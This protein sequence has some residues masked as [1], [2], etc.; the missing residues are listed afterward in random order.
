MY[1]SVIGILA[2]LVLNIIN[3][4][5]I[6]KK[7]TAVL[8]STQKLYRRYL[9]SICFFYLT[10]IVWG[11][12]EYYNQATLLFYD[13]EL[14]FFAIALSIFLWARYVV[15]YLGEDV[16]FRSFLHYSTII[17]LIFV[18]TV[19]IINLFYP[20]VFWIDPSGVYHAAYFRYVIFASQLILLFLVAGFTIYA[21]LKN[22][23]STANRF[24]TIAFSTLTTA[25][26]IVLQLVFPYLPM[27]SI[28]LMLSTCLLRSF[29]IEIEKE[30]YRK[31]LE[32]SF[33]EL[34]SAWKSAYTD[35]MTGAKNKLAY[36]EASEEIDQAIS[37]GTMKSFAIAV[38]DVN[39]LKQINDNLGHSAGDKCIRAAYRLISE[40]F[41]QSPLFRIGGDEFVC[42]LKGSDF[43][44]RKKLIDTFNRI[45]ENN[46]ANHSIVVS[47]GVATYREGEDFS[48]NKLFE[49]ADHR[50]YERKTEL[51]S[52]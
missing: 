9:F 49:R 22:R 47:I 14:Y 45:V 32:L 12:L 51:K 10:D 19:I 11:I 43:E 34:N 28:A 41:K 15:S 2:I 6:F 1:Y 29:V 48:F 21:A 44:N 39:G 8:P 52:S 26:L 42:I 35:S 4:D 17:F 23:D 36:F 37:N 13:T 3:Y 25:A 30:E 40:I 20:L 5:V 7:V 27:Y 24:V 46:K 16:F 31:S 33:T 18:T 38:F 50:M